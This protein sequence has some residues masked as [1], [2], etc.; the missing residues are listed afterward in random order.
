[1]FLVCFEW[2]NIG[3]FGFLEVGVVEGLVGSVFW[4][5]EG[6]RR[7]GRLGRFSCRVLGLG[8]F[9]GKK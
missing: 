2:G 8:S 3:V 4:R 1:M 9:E 6:G 7:W 5:R